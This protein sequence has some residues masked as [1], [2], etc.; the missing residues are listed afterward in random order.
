M[1]GLDR[2]I[3]LALRHPHDF[4]IQYPPR[5]EFFMDAFRSTVD[6]D[7]VLAPLSELPA[8]LL[9]VHVPFCAAKC[10]YC[11][12]SV[13]TRANDSRT[14]R[15]V[16]A[17]RGELE[18]LATR[19]H[20]TTVIPGI[21]IGGGTPTLL[22]TELLIELLEAL[23]PFMA[24]SDA[25]QLLSIETTPAI[26]ANEPDKLDALVSHGVRRI[27][28][29]LQ[30][31]NDETLARVNRG[32]QQAQT[33]RAL[34]NLTRVGFARVNAD[35]IFGLPGQTD[36]HFRADLEVVAGSGIDSIT[37]YDCLY[38]GKGRTLTRRAPRLPTHDDYQRL[39][40]MAFESLGR[41]GF[42]APYGS[43]NFSRHSA[44]TGTSAYFEGR[45][46][47]GMPYVGLGNYASSMVGDHWWFAPYQADTW[48]SRV[49]AG[50][51]LPIGD[52]YVLPL[53][54]R[55]AKH[56]LLSLSFG[57]L[58]PLRF[59]AVH[60]VALRDVYGAALERALDEGW[61]TLHPSGELR[62]SPGSFAALPRLRALFYTPRAIAWLERHG[63]ARSSAPSS[64][65]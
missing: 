51:S 36:D 35:L 10:F 31:T 5:R 37:T 15:Y 9:Y 52:S 17:L 4:T 45:L 13:D 44:E 1:T 40:D 7:R 12:F 48:W 24:R 57:R 47:D 21:D 23:V 50:E 42:F 34:A 2:H 60:G 49:E 11:N 46:L 38:R 18:A 27:S 64:T 32:Q 30:S 41:R 22:A 16:A 8:V 54:E 33:E 3:A 58:D 63:P 28:V 43:L 62:L 14:R 19:L 56:A 65:P 53:E 26:A 20:E 59:E 61:L 55:I 29:G 39:Y 25:A 6:R